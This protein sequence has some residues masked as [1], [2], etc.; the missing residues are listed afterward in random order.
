MNKWCKGAKGFTLLEL[1]LVVIV[2]G[3]LAALAL[4]QYTNFAEKAR[5]AEALSTMGAI[6]TAEELYKLETGNYTNTKADLAVDYQSAANTVTYWYYGI[7]NGTGGTWVNVTATRTTK[8]TS[9]D[10][11][12]IIWMNYTPATGEV[13]GGNHTGTPK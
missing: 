7:T 10:N 13:W 5:A 11:G 6:R 4:P 1:L 12:K 2:V 3:I 8:K 9:T